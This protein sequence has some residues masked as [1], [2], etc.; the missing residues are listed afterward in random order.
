MS[1]LAV[2]GSNSMVGS[3][4]CEMAEGEFEL[5]K[6]DLNGPI[7]LD[8]TDK[9]NINQFF[10]S[11][12]FE[13]VIL[14]SAFTDVDAAEQQRGDKNGPCWRIN[15]DGTENVAEAAA[16]FRKKLTILSTDF[17]FDGTAGP[18]TEEEPTGPDQNK[19]SWYGLTKIESEKKVKDVSDS[20]I[21]R[22][23]Y[24]YR[25]NFLPKEDF[26]RSILRKSKEGKLHPMFTDQKF[27]PTF[28][29][30]IYPAIKLLIEKKQYGIFHV[31]SPI[32]TTPFEFAKEVIITSGN[33]PKNLEEG[34]L[35]FFLKKENSTPRPLNGGMKVEKIKKL[36]FRP[37]DFKTG[38][39]ELF[40]QMESH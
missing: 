3:R 38:I 10:Q 37:T 18:Y 5:I 19:V 39:K 32:I 36:G 15:V 6:T 17:V 12:N 2:I 24:P 4:L 31:A 7:S 27:T 11:Q 9:K 35:N 16:K 8:I 29:D 33:N 23:S 25:A 22:I 20:I 14:F 30:D 21:I 28:T 40:N 34:S 13:Y 26:A 1:P